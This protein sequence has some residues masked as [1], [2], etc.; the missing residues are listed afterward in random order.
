MPTQPLFIPPLPKTPKLLS[1]IKIW[2]Q[3]GHNAFTDIIRHGDYFYVT[4]REAE[5]HVGS[6]GAIRVI[7]SRDGVAWESC[8]LLTEESIDLR[9]PK[10]SVTP[11]K[12]LML[13]MG[14][15]DYEGKELVGRQPRVAFSKNG[16]EWSVPQRV[17]SEGDWLWRVTWHEGRAYGVSNHYTVGED[18]PRSLLL[19]VSDD[20]VNFRIRTILDI[21]GNRFEVTARFMP[22]GSMMLLARREE[23]DK[24][25]YI[26]TSQDPYTDWSWNNTGIRVGGPDFIRLPDGSMWAGYRNYVKKATTEFAYMT[27]KHL[28]PVLTL[29][30]GGDTSYPGFVWHDDV[31][32]MTY[33]SSHEEKTSIYPLVA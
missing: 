20:G 33:Y 4:F 15:S 1:V 23:D 25:G 6:D 30:S 27:E 16:T 11:D 3:G 22:D 24:G 21:T 2:D 8:G 17:C 10:I 5:N 26:G 9:D 13:V 29:P 12:R 14:G 32:W 18:A 7:R 19:Y 28:K 31:L